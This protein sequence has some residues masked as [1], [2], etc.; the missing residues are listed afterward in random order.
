ME[1]LDGFES[2][3]EL[4]IE[5]FYDVG[6]F[7]T[8]YFVPVSCV[9]VGS[10][11][12][13]VC[14][15]MIHRCNLD[16]VI[17]VLRAAPPN[18]SFESIFTE[19]RNIENVFLNVFEEC[20]VVFNGAHSKLFPDVLEEVHMADLYDDIGEDILCRLFDC[21]IIIT[22]H[23]NKRVIHILEFREELHPSFEAL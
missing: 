19:H 20:Y 23:G 7:G 15:D 13:C 22:C 10:E 16:V 11:I 5:A 6:S 3:F 21:R 18:A 14:E 8:R 4:A 1:A 2:S 9:Y 12:L 17:L